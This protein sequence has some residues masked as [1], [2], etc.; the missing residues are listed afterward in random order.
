[1][2]QEHIGI[3]VQPF[4]AYAS[5][6][7]GDQHQTVDVVT[8]LQAS[9]AG[10]AAA[11]GAR[12]RAARASVLACLKVDQ[13]ARLL[14]STLTFLAACSEASTASRPARRRS[15]ARSA[16]ASASASERVTCT[17]RGASVT[18]R[19]TCVWSS[20][21]FRL[22]ERP[23]CLSGARRTSRSALKARLRRYSAWRVTLRVCG[24]APKVPCSTGGTPAVALSLC[25]ALP[26]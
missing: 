14:S 26:L 9:G 11:A 23:R 4:L 18:T 22:G 13:S 6:M 10:R 25:L 12:Q 24:W 7:R 2:S 1:M 15:A 17:A 16:A 20:S 5:N 21:A 3:Q 19:P 8:V